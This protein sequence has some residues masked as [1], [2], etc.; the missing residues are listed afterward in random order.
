MVGVLSGGVGVNRV[1]CDGDGGWD[2]EWDR[3]GFEYGMGYFLVRGV[4]FEWWREIKA[5]TASFFHLLNS[6]G[7]RECVVVWGFFDLL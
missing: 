2:F 7:G 4:C 3:G 6:V 5:K 1:W